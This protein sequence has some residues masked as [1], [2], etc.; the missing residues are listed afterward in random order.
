MKIIGNCYLRKKENIKLCNEIITEYSENRSTLS[1]KLDFG[2]NW[3]SHFLG[4]DKWNNIFRKALIFENFIE[5]Q[6]EK[7][8]NKRIKRI[9][10]RSNIALLKKF[11]SFNH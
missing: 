6:H 4:W 8:N 5:E 2:K 3:R 7:V 1:R 10:K 11:Q 9:K